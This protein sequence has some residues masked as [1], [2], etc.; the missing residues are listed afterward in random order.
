MLFPPLTADLPVGSSMQLYDVPGP[1]F[2]MQAVHI[3]SDD[4]LSPA[5]ALH[6]S[7]GMVSSVGLYR[8]KLM[9]PGKAPG[10]IPGSALLSSH[11]LHNACK[12]G[13]Y[14][15]SPARSL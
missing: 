8:G 7:Q 4:A 1:C 3:L 13:L 6:F 5:H 2:V 11:E 9:P 14:D 12:S 10:P 15:S